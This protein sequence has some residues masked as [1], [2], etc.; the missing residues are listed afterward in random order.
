MA[1][2]L[3]YRLHGLLAVVGV[4][5]LRHVSAC[6][7]WVRCARIGAAGIG[8]HS[9]CVLMDEETGGDHPSSRLLRSRRC[10][11]RMGP[12]QLDGRHCACLPD[13]LGY[14]GIFYVTRGA[15]GFPDRRR[16]LFLAIGA[17]AGHLWKQVI[18][19]SGLPM[20][21]YPALLARVAPPAER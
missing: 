7:L 13:S 16:P 14:D 20:F 15:R 2:F 17:G 10:V 11:V 5:I 18:L 3:L 8:L 4:G 1:P 6:V 12:H 19:K 9:R 21:S